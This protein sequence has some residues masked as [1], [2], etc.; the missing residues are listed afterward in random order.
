MSKSIEI[1]SKGLEVQ[2]QNEKNTILEGKNS[3]V[4]NNGEKI[5]IIK[6]LDDKELSFDNLIV[7]KDGN[8][9]TIAYADGTSVVIKDFY[10]LE[11]LT[12]ELPT[13]ESE[14]HLIS[15]NFEGSSFSVVYGQG[16]L[17]A[18]ESMF[19]GNEVALHALS[20]YSNQLESGLNAGGEV[21]SEGAVATGAATSGVSTAAL[22]V[23]GLVVVGGVVAASNSSNGGGGSSDS[24]TSISSGYLVD[25]PVAGATYK[26]FIDTNNNGI[27]DGQETLIASG[28]T[29][30]DGSFNYSAGETIVFEIAG[31]T[32]GKMTSSEISADGKVFPQDILGLERTDVTDS[33]VTNMAKLLQTLDSDGDPSNGITVETNENGD[34]VTNNGDVIITKNDI[35]N[36]TGNTSN[37]NNLLQ[38]VDTNATYEAGGNVSV[39][40][41][42]EAQAHILGTVLGTSDISTITASNVGELADLII[43]GKT[44]II[45]D[46]NIDLTDLS[47]LVTQTTITQEQADAIS[48]Y[49]GSILVNDLTDN[50]ISFGLTLSQYEAMSVNATGDDSVN[51][52][53]TDS[54]ANEG[55]HGEPNGTDII[56][57]TGYDLSNADFITISANK[58]VEVNVAQ[59]A[60]I[61]NNSSSAYIE[62]E[63]VYTNLLDSNLTT[64]QQI[65]LQN[66]NQVSI[67]LTENTDLSNV[68]LNSSVDRI[69][70]E[71]YTLTTSIANSIYSMNTNSLTV[72]S[73]I[74][75][76]FPNVILKDT[77]SNLLNAYSSISFEEN[78]IITD[79]VTIN[80]ISQVENITNGTVQYSSIIDTYSVLTDSQNANYFTSNPNVNISS[81]ITVAQLAIVDSFTTGNLTY[82]LNDSLQNLAADSTVLEGATNYRL[83]DSNADLGAI[84]LKEAQIVEGASNYISGNFTYSLAISLAELVAAEKIPS[85]YTLLD[86]PK[87]INVLTLKEASIVDGASNKNNYNYSILDTVENIE[88]NL[89]QLQNLHAD[90]TLTDTTI[91]VSKLSNISSYVSS[92]QIIVEATTLTGTS[93]DV[94]NLFNNAYSIKIQN[95]DIAVTINDAA[96]SILNPLT[97]G[98]IAQYTT[99]NVTILNTVTLYGYYSDI[100]NNKPSNLVFPSSTNFEFRDSSLTV[101]QLNSVDALTPGIIKANVS[102]QD[103]SEALTITDVNGN[104]DYSLDLSYQ[105]VTVQELNSL[106]LL[107]SNINSY[108]LT[109]TLANLETVKDLTGI[110][111][112]VYSYTDFSK[113]SVAQAA[114]L[115]NT[116]SVYS[117]AGQTPLSTPA[118]SLADTL[119]NLETVN[120]TGI[121]Y[122][123]YSYDDTTAISVAQAAILNN[124]HTVYSD[125][126]QTSMTTPVLY[127]LADTL[128]NLETVNLTGISY[129]VYS[130]DDTTA[131]SVAQAA[132]LNNAHTV[133]SDAGQISMTTP[134]FYSLADTLANLETLGNLYGM[135]DVYSY[136]DTTAISV[137]QAAILNNAHTVYSDAG[138]IPIFYPVSYMISDTASAIN[139]ADSL[140]LSDASDV[141]ATAKDGD[142]ITLFDLSNVHTLDISGTVTLTDTQASLVSL[143]DTG[144]LDIVFNNITTFNLSSLA[145]STD[146]NLSVSSID[147]RNLKSDSITLTTSDLLDLGGILSLNIE[148]IDSISIDG[149]TDLS[150]G[151]SG[152]TKGADN[153]NYSVYTNDIDNTLELNIS[154]DGQVIA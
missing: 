74:D 30:A 69:I 149:D 45:V 82:N 152:W 138:Q 23:G 7:V 145:D 73:G 3:F 113:L 85:T 108:T 154:V 15:S 124:A 139:G 102:V 142:D 27:L 127:S 71:G 58:T 83:N 55:L 17:T 36:N 81:D 4:L 59:V 40:S 116:H 115:S 79:E 53:I 42:Q 60:K 106:N 118:Y 107:Y 88:N 48:N 111:Y 34:I 56:N 47:G 20:E 101:N 137:A 67:T 143:S 87:D 38:T 46:G 144:N 91:E 2:L 103:I 109:D 22:V 141:L 57:L 66:A 150:D 97:L 51:I 105:N 134:V 78:I 6:K 21:A 8:D 123:V 148:G 119:A 18:F 39:V 33:R 130:Y 12:L 68:I 93:N 135:Y 52:L 10:T 98:Y 114:I 54:D 76:E 11:D 49:T 16:D 112:E 61:K 13:A 50:K 129:D 77:A 94:S 151:I 72:I 121:S 37:I 128:A 41:D 5:K 28:T 64:A 9:L 75:G 136:D 110:S 70:T 63:D 35:T 126:G 19:A 1:I 131:I 92:N 146:T 65:A 133:Y 43:S 90:I 86:D 29:S 80:D 125:A 95:S 31:I 147:A 140:V 122:D 132:I 25:S 104:N 14:M 100:V 32:L 26:R 84:S 120:L 96:N 89:Q 62:V 44:S 24:S 99:G 117:D 153:G